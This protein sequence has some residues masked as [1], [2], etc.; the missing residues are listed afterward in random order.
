MAMELKR[1]PVKNTQV[2]LDLVSLGLSLSDDVRYAKAREQNLKEI[3]ESI[4]RNKD[5]QRNASQ[6]RVA[7]KVDEQ[8]SEVST[9]HRPR[10]S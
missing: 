1:L 7:A 10:R 4:Q 2:E 9:F 8:E 5:L 6:V 3:Y